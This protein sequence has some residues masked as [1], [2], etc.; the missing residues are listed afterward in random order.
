MENNYYIGKI[1]HRRKI[2]QI[3]IDQTILY[4][5]DNYHYLDLINKKMYDID[6]RKKD[7]IIKESLKE[8][9][10]NEFKI[11]HDNLVKKYKSKGK[12]KSARN[13]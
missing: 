9:D 3:K 7:Y 6:N 12:I 11:E 5:E 8:I 13:K 1:Y 10:I 4:T 2:R